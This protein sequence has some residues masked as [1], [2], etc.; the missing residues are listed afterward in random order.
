V[1]SG[2]PNERAHDALRRL[3]RIDDGVPKAHI[4]N[5]YLSDMASGQRELQGWERDH[6]HLCE[7]C[8][9]VL[10]VLLMA[11]GEEHK[12]PGDDAA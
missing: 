3:L 10:Y 7:V 11:A 2:F 6:I 4:E 9:A 5:R 1:N 8:Q 12:E